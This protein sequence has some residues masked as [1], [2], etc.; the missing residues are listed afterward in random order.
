MYNEIRRRAEEK[1]EAKKGFYIT[2]IVFSFISII[3]I[4]IGMYI[5]SI[6]FWLR[7]PIPIFMMVLVIMYFA[8][9]GLP[10]SGEFSD[11]WT[12]DEVIR[13]MIRIY[14]KERSELPPPDDALWLDEDLELK[15]MEKE[16]RDLE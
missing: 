7:L 4:M 3:L 11:D 6:A 16:K 15:E 8:I 5:P 14:K 9:F 2:A 13:E 12:E 10:S 1:V